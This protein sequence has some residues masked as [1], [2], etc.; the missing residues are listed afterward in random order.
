MARI[1]VISGAGTGIGAATARALAAT[2]TDLVL[3]G[4]R[5]EP[6]E[7]V[8]EELSRS[9]P[10]VR[11]YP[12]QV[13]V[14]SAT[15]VEGLRSWADINLSQIDV[16]VNNAGSVQPALDGTLANLAL[17][18][19]QTLRAN[20]ISVVL[21]TEA[22]LPSMPTPG[23]R[24]IIVGS[25]GARFGTGGPAYAAAKGALETYARTLCRLHGPKGIT[26]NVVAPGYTSDTELVIGRIPPERHDRLL[27]GIAV[28]RPAA[29]PEIASVIA[30]L[31]SEGASFINGETVSANGGMLMPG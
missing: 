21:L 11:V 3:L 20:L 13:D 18:W 16:V 1:A 28:G 14:S 26:A 2:C 31:A 24:I 12:R 22:L 23:G 10:T 15:D 25:S 29:S 7:S 4:R 19:D 6:L 9:H 8:T 27:T 30:F 17:V 5:P